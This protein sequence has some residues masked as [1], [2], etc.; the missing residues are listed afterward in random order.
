[1]ALVSDM[2]S[3]RLMRLD[4]LMV[5]CSFKYVDNINEVSVALIY[6][7]NIVAVSLTVIIKVVSVVKTPL[8][9]LRPL[10]IDIVSNVP[11]VWD[12]IN[13]VAFP[14]TPYTFLRSC[15]PLIDFT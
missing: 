5:S 10:D 4:K 3:F 6:V 8:F 12:P 7:D 11:F 14:V 13:F 2:F 1:M 9:K 15:H